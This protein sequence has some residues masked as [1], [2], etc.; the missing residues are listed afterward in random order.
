MQKVAIVGGGPAGLVAARFL[1]SEGF[2]PVLFEQADSLGGQWS[3]DARFSGIWPSLHTNTSRVHTQFSDLSHAPDLP[4]YPSNRDIQNYLRRYAEHFDLVSRCRLSCPVRE[5]ARAGNGWAV[6]HDHAEEVFERVVVASGRFHHP[7]TPAVRGLDSFSGSE[8]V[9]HTYAYKHP[10]RYR[11]KRVLVAGCAI[12][13]L[14]IASDL[15]ML[16]AASV[17]VCNRRQ[18]YVLPKLAAGVP[19]DHRVFTRYQ[20]LAEESLPRDEYGRALKELVL[21]AGG[22]PEQYGAPRPADSL[23]DAGLTLCQHYLPMVAEGRIEVRPW[24]DRVEGSRVTFADGRDAHFDG[25]LFGTGFE[26]RLPFLGEA[27]ARVLN[28][29]SQNVDLYQRTL[30]PDL[31][32]L[33]FM[34]LWDQAGPY[35][36]PLELQARWLAYVWSGAVA[37]PTRDEMQE[38]IDEF[39]ARRMHAPKTKMNLVALSFARAAGVEPDLAR[40]PQL[41]R[42]LLFGPLAPVSFRLQGRDALPDAAD[43]FEAE[44]RAF[45][46]VTSPRLSEGEALGLRRLAQAR[47]EPA[48]AEVALALGGT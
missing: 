13:A 7:W 22:S 31:P 2:E 32:G 24:I 27:I 33:A 21:A 12:S 26:L 5:I 44:A 16:G 36:P 6:R 46:C 9:S 34:G 29:D 47:D 18:R 40:W 37:M 1:K 39:R 3:G 11:G 8:G 17:V 15:C 28:L 45:G 10:D 25:L 38:S 23:F 42:A 41:Q 30:H 20:A 19:S 35:L 43:R 48:L 14:E 4:V